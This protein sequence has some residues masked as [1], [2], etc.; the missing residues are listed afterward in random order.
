MDIKIG[1]VVKV[2]KGTFTGLIEVDYVDDILVQGRIPYATTYI[3][4]GT[5]EGSYRG[6]QH[7][8]RDQVLEVVRRG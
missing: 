6:R 7:A 4:G 5:Y 3:E 2:Q 1:D 8:W